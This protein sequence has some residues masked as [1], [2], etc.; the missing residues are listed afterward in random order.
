MSVANDHAL[1]TSKRIYVLVLPHVS[2]AWWDSPPHWTAVW[3]SMSN[4]PES[5]DRG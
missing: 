5:T 4:R 1:V 2:E 3:F